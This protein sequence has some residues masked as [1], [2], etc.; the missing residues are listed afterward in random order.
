MPPQ[1][2]FSGQWTLVAAIP[3]DDTAATAL[4]VRQTVTRTTIRGEPMAPFFRTIDIDRQFGGR[5]TTDTHLIGIVGGTVAGV[6]GS[7][8]RPGP[9]RATQSRYA[10][11]WDGDTLVF[12]FGTY[13][14]EP[15]GNGDWT[16]RRETWSLQPNGEFAIVIVTRGSAAAV[17]TE[18]ATYRRRE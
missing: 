1:P 9:T 7:R 5:T 8:G 2:D 12:E 15:Q 10:A 16:E 4:T 6:V 14:G 3:S 13:A 11:R 18:S 17:R